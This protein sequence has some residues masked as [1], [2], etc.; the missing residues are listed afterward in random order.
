MA[1]ILGATVIG[2]VSSKEKEDLATDFGADYV[3]NYSHEDVVA[4]VHEITNG[5]GCHAVLDGLTYR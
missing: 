5:Q 4:R 2:T 3:I 1:K